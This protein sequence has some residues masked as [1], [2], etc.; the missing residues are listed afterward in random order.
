MKSCSRISTVSRL[1]YK[2]CLL[3]IIQTMSTIHKVLSRV[4]WYVLFQH[5]S[6]HLLLLIM[7]SIIYMHECLTVH[8]LTSKF[9]KLYLVQTLGHDVCQLLIR[10]YPF[11]LDK[12]ISDFISDVVMSNIN[13][14]GTVM[15]DIIF[16]Y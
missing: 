6:L 11:D 10:L 9:L 15:M 8:D 14:F 12:F 1:Y 4:I 5:S 13:V 2:P 7:I 16:T 3:Y